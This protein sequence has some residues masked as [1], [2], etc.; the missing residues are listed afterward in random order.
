MLKKSF[1]TVFAKKG[2]FPPERRIE[3]KAS[4]YVG[5]KIPHRTNLDQSYDFIIILENEILS[6][7]CRSFELMNTWVNTLKLKLRELKI[8]SPKENFY[9]RPPVMR[10]LH[11]TRNPRDPLPE[12]PENGS[13]VERLIPGLELEQ[14][15]SNQNESQEISSAP[16][17]EENSQISNENIITN[18]EEAI[19][20]ITH[21]QSLIESY[22]IEE[23]SVTIPIFPNFAKSN[24]SSQNIINLLSNPLMRHHENVTGNSANFSTA[25]NLT[26]FLDLDEEFEGVQNE[27]EEEILPTSLKVEYIPE[28]EV[29]ENIT[30]IPVSSEAV[31]V[32]ESNGIDPSK[33]TKIKIEV[34]YDYLYKSSSSSLSPTHP[35]EDKKSIKVPST[36]LPT[37]SSI[38]KEIRSAPCTPKKLPLTAK[39]TPIHEKRKSLREQQVFKMKQ[40][41][42]TEIRFKLRKKDC[43]DAIAFIS[44]KE[45]LWIAGKQNLEVQKFKFF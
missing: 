6:F 12:R 3:L 21:I 10:P 4:K 23:D 15:L 11:Q 26:E 35:V 8:L 17:D 13:R 2:V 44:F 37:T 14:E 19:E 45:S 27:Q 36:S 38:V 28:K 16:D 24:T 7:G 34:D 22:T 31:E 42:G 32:K 1:L 25:N 5:I 9:S 41:I 43:I 30:I 29:D 18:E 40:E 20:E 39:L 33:V